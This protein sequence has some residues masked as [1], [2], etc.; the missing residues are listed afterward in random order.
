MLLSP[1]SQSLAW[2]RWVCLIANFH[3]QITLSQVFCGLPMP[4]VLP[5]ELPT[6]LYPTLSILSIAPNHL[7]YHFVC[8]L[9]P[10]LPFCM[11]FL[12]LSNCRQS[13]NSSEDFLYFNFTSHIHYYHHVISLQLWQ[14]LIFYCPCLTTIENNTPDTSQT[15]AISL[16]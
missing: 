16:P 11:Q 12:T 5:L 14:V 6:H 3:S 8:H 9:P 4:S 2:V 15:P 10:C 13:L 7:V 1:P